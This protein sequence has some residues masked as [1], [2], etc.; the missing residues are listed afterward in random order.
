MRVSIGVITKDFN[1]LEPIDEFLENASKHNHKI[2]SIIIVYSHGCDFRLVESL[3][4]KVK[5][6]LV[7]INDVPEIK[8]QLTKTGLSTENIEIL[9]SCPT[10]KKYGKVPYGLNRNYALIKAL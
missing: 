7:K 3:E 8:R 1:S 6:F 9:L 5:V 4:K 10:L 2:Y